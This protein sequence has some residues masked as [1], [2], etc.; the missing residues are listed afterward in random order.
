MV[1]IPLPEGQPYV[2]GAID[3]LYEV[4]LSANKTTKILNPTMQ[5]AV[6]A[7]VGISFPVGGNSKPEWYG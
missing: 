1:F 7:G 5:P 2:E 4:W 6:F 3:A